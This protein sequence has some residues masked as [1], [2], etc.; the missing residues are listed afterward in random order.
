MKKNLLKA[1]TY[2]PPE[3]NVLQQTLTLSFMQGSDVVPSGMET[4]ND[5]G[6]DDSNWN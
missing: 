4:Y 6:D 5:M 3:C 1:V 2:C